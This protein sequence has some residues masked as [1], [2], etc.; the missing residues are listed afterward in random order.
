[1]GM[2]HEEKIGVALGTWF[3]KRRCFGPQPFIG[4][5]S[6]SAE[7]TCLS[8]SSSVVFGMYSATY[9]LCQLTCVW[10]ARRVCGGRG[11]RVKLSSMSTECIRVISHLSFKT[12][13][14]AHTQRIECTECVWGVQNT[15]TRAAHAGRWICTEVDRR[16]QTPP[17]PLASSLARLDVELTRRLVWWVQHGIFGSTL[18]PSLCV[19]SSQS[20]LHDDLPY[21]C[22]TL[23]VTPPSSKH[24]PGS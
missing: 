8:S 24:H 22:S 17:F 10:E 23:R 21:S 1:M 4:C 20:V 19:Y 18:H 6:A 14:G 15:T 5:A 16:L 9:L 7:C 11:M 13:V 3:V 12:D 2:H